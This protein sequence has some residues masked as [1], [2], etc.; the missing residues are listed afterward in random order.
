MRA[1]RFSPLPIRRTGDDKPAATVWAYVW[2]MSGWHQVCVA[3]LALM[4][5]GL[6]AVP[7]DLQR[8][9][10]D[11]AIADR[12]LDSLILL[13]GLYLGVVLLQAALKFT[14]RLYQAWLSESA[15][16][17]TRGHL[18]S[19]FDRHMEN[20]EADSGEATSI[21][22]AEVDKLGGFVGDAIA[23]PIVQAGTLVALLGYMIMVEPLVA[24]ISTVI[25][26]IQIAIVPPLQACVNKRITIH[27]TLARRLGGN[28]SRRE[29]RS[30]H[31]TD[32]PEPY[33]DPHSEMGAEGS[34]QSDEQ[35]GPPL[36]PGDRRLAGDRGSDQHRG[37]CRVH[38]RVRPACG[39]RARPDR[40]FPSSV[41]GPRSARYDREVDVTDPHRKKR[42]AWTA[43]LG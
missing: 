25:L 34:G 39:P 19:I 28:D 35:S 5:A 1:P 32:L 9:I 11:D 30:D 22:N 2:R 29:T 7:L 18:L 40:L 27:V 26:A 12:D 23:Q 14:V 13:A 20:S 17:Y 16:R 37:G 4:V 41:A 10:V 3:L 15:I 6:G 42:E 8:R 21:I 33:D 31:Q 24:T 43:R 36:G 38:V